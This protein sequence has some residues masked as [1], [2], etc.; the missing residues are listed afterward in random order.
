[1]EKILIENF[2]GINNMEFDFKSINILIGPQGSGKS[3]TVK[4][5]YFFKNFINE[6]IKSIENEET[7]RDLDQK[8]KETFIT[9]FPKESWSKEDFFISYSYESTS[10]YIKKIDNK[11]NFDYSDN[12]KAVI[13]KGKKIYQDEKAKL[14][15]N[16]KVPNFSTKRQINEKIQKCV[17]NELGSLSTFDQFFIPAGRSFFANIQSS[18][19]S[20]LSDNRSLDP[21]L[22]EFGSFYENLKRFYNDLLSDEKNDKEYDELISEILNSTYVREKEKDYLVHKDHRKVN[23]TNASSGQQ[24]TLPLIII[25][26][27]LTRINSVGG[28]FTLYIE[29]PEAHL[30]PTAQKRIVELLA[31]TFNSTDNKFQIFVT[32][33]SPYILSSFNNLIY[34]GNIKNKL[35]S[36]GK[37]NY[38]LNKIIPTKEQLESDMFSVYS[39]RNNEQ[40]YLIEKDSKLISPTI[41]DSVSDEISVEFDKLLNIDFSNEL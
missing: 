10:I 18:I 25:L 14:L 33:H 22:I 34:S 31:R 16:R 32:T 19:F 29:E 12:V 4:L 20:F 37:K 26:K 35:K 21:F 5:L 23:L 39:L 11:I 24:E 3:I 7:K 30:F 41:L 36:E 40:R 8:Q 17:K 1:M 6:I 28:G 38:K 27:T 15:E 13:K 9:F 2:G